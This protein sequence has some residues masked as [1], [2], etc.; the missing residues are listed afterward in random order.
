MYKK[1]ITGIYIYNI[2]L[3]RRTGDSALV[4]HIL[5]VKMR[6][7][8]L[9]SHHRAVVEDETVQLGIAVR[10]ETVLRPEHV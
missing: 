1:Y 6:L 7:I 9:P 8:L 3:Y 2:D 4:K 10:V 5:A